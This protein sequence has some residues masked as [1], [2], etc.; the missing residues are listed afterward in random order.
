MR[1]LSHQNRLKLAVVRRPWF[2]RR[3]HKREIAVL[4]LVALAPFIVGFASRSVLL[5]IESIFFAPVAIGAVLWLRGDWTLVGPHF[6]YDLIRLARRGRSINV[7]VLYVIILLLGLGFVY[8]DQLGTH[9]DLANSLFSSITV[10]TADMRNEMADL[11]ERYVAIVIILQNLAVMLLAP[12]Y[13][14]T[15]ITEER[16]RR[17]LEMLFTTHL[18]DREIVIGKLTAR[19]VHIGGVLLAGLPILSLSQ[20]LGGVDMVVLLANFLNT[21]LLLMTVG[22]TSI[23]ISTLARSAL[24]AVLISYSILLP[25][26]VC[27]SCMSWQG[28]SSLVLLWQKNFAGGG[29]ELVAVVMGAFLLLHGLISATCLGVAISSLRSYLDTERSSPR[30][31]A[32]DTEEYW[33]SKE[34][35]TPALHTA[36]LTGLGHREPVEERIVRRARMR[37]L[38][39]LA[40][41]PLIWKEMYTGGRIIA[42]SPAFWIPLASLLAPLLLIFTL[43]LLG[44]TYD[45]G[46]HEAELSNYNLFVRGTLLLLAGLFCLGV[47]YRTST[48][49]AR[50]RQQGTLDALL[51]L[52]IPRQSILRSKWIGALYKGWGWALIFMPVV[53]VGF[54]VGVLHFLGAVFLLLAVGV[55]AA[56]LASLGLFLS[57]VSARVLTAQFRMALLLFA[58]LMALAIELFVNDSTGLVNN[59]NMIFN[60]LTGWNFLC[61]IPHEWSAAPDNMALVLIGIGFYAVVAWILWVVTCRLFER[62]RYRK[63]D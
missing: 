40:D 51:M 13:I 39:P 23:L 56:F 45:R 55:F 26:A 16:E 37:S 5:T 53:T 49:V 14:A 43:M 31:I 27:F 8:V 48:G 18:S 47:A 54:A 52:P 57:V 36:G 6:Y 22:A 28:N 20:L 21:A 17:T 30:L 44:V 7:R 4:A 46:R 58:F 25:F 24:S 33:L 15:A 59:A 9:R 42:F 38:P 12:A 50:E 3:W 63:A 2:R 1:Q 10:A 11:A 34:E 60:P 41:D 61:S 62:D 32:A 19:A 35:R 29:Y